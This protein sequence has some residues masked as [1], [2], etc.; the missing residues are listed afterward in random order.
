[1]YKLKISIVNRRKVEHTSL[2]RAEVGTVSAMSGPSR[3]CKEKKR[4]GEEM[5]ERE[6]EGGGGDEEGGGGRGEG[7]SS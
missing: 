7:K 5:N 6:D 1:M 3:V 4:I 2:P